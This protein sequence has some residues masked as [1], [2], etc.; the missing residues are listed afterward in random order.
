MV[1]RPKKVFRRF[2]TASMIRAYRMW[3]RLLIELRLGLISGWSVCCL[4]CCRWLPRAGIFVSDGD[5]PLPHLP[6]YFF[7]DPFLLSAYDRGW[8]NKKEEDCSRS[9]RKCC[10]VEGR[11]RVRGRHTH[12]NAS[13]LPSPRFLDLYRNS[14]C[15][16]PPPP[17]PIISFVSTPV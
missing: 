2:W 17:P 10:D 4:V 14:I 15:R 16:T 12:Y 1:R 3:A 9:K 11:W 13:C 5:A 8:T 6:P 7:V